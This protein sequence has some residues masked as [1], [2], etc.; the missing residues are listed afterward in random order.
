MRFRALVAQ[1]RQ[2]ASGN[3]R[4]GSF[5]DIF[6]PGAVNSQGNFELGF[7]GHAASM[8]AG[9]FTSVDD[10]CVM[11]GAFGNCRFCFSVKSCGRG[12]EGGPLANAAD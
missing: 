4:I 9:A 3:V 1:A 11:Y 12:G 8:A 5:F 10:H 2:K 6:D 7:A